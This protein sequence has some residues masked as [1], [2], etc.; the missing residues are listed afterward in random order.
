MVTFAV[1]LHFGTAVL[2]S[3]CLA[4]TL[5]VVH[6]EVKGQRNTGGSKLSILTC[7]GKEWSQLITPR[8]TELPLLLSKVPSRVQSPNT[9]VL[10]VSLA[11]KIA[12]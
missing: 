3:C 11:S 2:V 12:S 4:N 5:G 8:H 6:N 7:K 1:A 9:S 10:A